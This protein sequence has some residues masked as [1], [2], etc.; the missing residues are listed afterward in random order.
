MGAR[1]NSHGTPDA[2]AGSLT[3]ANR[4]FHEVLD[5]DARRNGDWVF[6]RHIRRVAVRVAVP[7]RRTTSSLHRRGGGY[8]PPSL[9]VL[10]QQDPRPQ[11]NGTP[12]STPTNPRTQAFTPP[13][14]QLVRAA[15]GGTCYQARPSPPT[16]VI[17][18]RLILAAGVKR[19]F[20]RRPG[21]LGKSFPTLR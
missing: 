20:P 8:H 16:T 15:T 14:R 19:T 3:E 17:C 13:L 21:V 7:Q 9:L 10:D 12:T 2:P 6:P 11:S 4:G 1:G 5:A 18:Y